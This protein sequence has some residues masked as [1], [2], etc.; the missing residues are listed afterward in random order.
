MKSIKP[1]FILLITLSTFA[2]PIIAAKASGITHFRDWAVGCSTT[3]KGAES[4]GMVQQHT[5]KDSK[6]VVM[7]ILISRPE[8]TTD[9]TCIITLPK[10]VA[11]IPGVQIKIDE[12]TAKVRPYKV[13]TDAGCVIAFKLPPENIKRMKAGTTMAVTFVQF[14]GTAVNVNASLKGFTEAFNSLQK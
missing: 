12:G 11:L 4:C 10:G 8:N 14:P 2:S 5:K 3:A 1:I 13:C 6:E 9:A 7:K